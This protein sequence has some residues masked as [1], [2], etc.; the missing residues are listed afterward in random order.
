MDP[1]ERRRLE[2][3]QEEE[4][5]KLALDTLGLGSVTSSDSFPK[6][7]QTEEEFAEFADA[8]VKKVRELRESDK[9][10]DFVDGLVTK[11]CNGC[12]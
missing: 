3:L 10:V 8:I 2:K 7:P 4:D 5:A 9:Y 12:E 1:A 6:N 11:L